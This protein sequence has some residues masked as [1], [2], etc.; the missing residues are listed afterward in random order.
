MSIEPDKFQSTPSGG[1]AT[2]RVRVI[3][4][5]VNE[6]QST[7]SGGKATYFRVP[8]NTTF[9]F[10]STPSGG[11]ATIRRCVQSSS[12]TVS[13]HAFRGEG[14][15]SSA[16]LQVFRDVS[17]HAFR[18]EGDSRTR[19][20]VRLLAGFN[21]RLPGGR[22]LRFC[23][24]MFAQFCF[25]PRLPGGRRPVA[26]RQTFSFLSFNPR[27]PGGRRLCASDRPRKALTFQST[28]SGGKATRMQRIRLVVSGVSIHAFRGEGDVNENGNAAIPTCFNPRLP[29]GRRPET[30]TRLLSSPTFQSTPSGGKATSLMFAQF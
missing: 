6:F 28:P 5:A 19:F 25:N 8:D 15:A 21:P 18:G 30:I 16:A 22:R 7:P 3:G 23:S 11:K 14:D 26:F 27:L 4:S 29:G 20:D 12:A 10:Q 1:K 17:I 9:R 24:L 2:F 13:I